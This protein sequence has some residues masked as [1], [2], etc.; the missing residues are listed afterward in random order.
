MLH[1]TAWDDGTL[2]DLI[3]RVLSRVRN[4]LVLIKEAKVG[5]I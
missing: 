2:D 1:L 4:V 5:K 3:G